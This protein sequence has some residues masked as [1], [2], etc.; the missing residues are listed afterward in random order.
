MLSSFFVISW[1]ISTYPS[2]FPCIVCI[3]AFSTINEDIYFTILDQQALILLIN[4]LSHHVPEF[5]S[6]VIARRNVNATK[7]TGST[8]FRGR[9]RKGGPRQDDICSWRVTC[10]LGSLVWNVRDTINKFGIELIV[11]AR[12]NAGFSFF[13]GDASAV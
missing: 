7:Q 11:D 2:F 1:T 13:N 4:C 12:L 6:S 5:E 10:S 9:I 3:L 8:S